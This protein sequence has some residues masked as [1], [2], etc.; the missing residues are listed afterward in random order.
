MTNDALF[1]EPWIGADYALLRERMKTDSL[2]P[3][4]WAYPYHVMGES[5]YG[6]ASQHKRD[7]TREIVQSCGFSSGHGKCSAFFAKVLKV[8]RADEH[9]ELTRPQHWQKLAF[10][11]F[12]QELMTGPGIAPTTAQLDRARAGF[13]AQLKLTTPQVLLV[14]GQRTWRELPRDFGFPISELQAMEDPA[15]V[16]K[17]AWAYVYEVAGIKHL[18]VAVYV[19]HPSAGGGVFK[20]EKAAIRART[21]GIYHSNLEVSDQYESCLAPQLD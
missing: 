17:D 13:R 4:V 3:G 11:N 7:L 20:W 19:I 18:T 8:V 10:S 9:P 14:L 21:V 2:E 6:N 15:I 16:V 1:F 5:H 12:V